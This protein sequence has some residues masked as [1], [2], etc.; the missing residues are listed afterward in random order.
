[1][2]TDATLQFSGFGGSK[3]KPIGCF[4]DIVSIDDEHF[5]TTI[6][7]VADEIMTMEAV[8]GN[9]LLSQAN[10]NISQDNIIISKTVTMNYIISPSY[11]VVM[12]A[13][14]VR[15]DVQLEKRREVEG[16]LNEYKPKKIKEA[17]V[18]MTIIMKEDQKIF[19]RPR[20]LQ[21]PERRIIS[22]QMEQWIKEIIEPCSS[23]YAS[24]IVVTK[25]KMVRHESVLTIVQSIEQ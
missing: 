9:E 12:D 3:V 21:F 14:T 2:L 16:L 15:H 5:R 13:P 7:V 6:Y 25:K 4:E 24:P 22:E 19:A 17:N 20:R 1:V 10:V 23:D 11:A 8:T 18:E